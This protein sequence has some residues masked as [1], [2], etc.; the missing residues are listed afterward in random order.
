MSCKTMKRIVAVTLLISVL[1]SFAGCG[2]KV[3]R[4][5][6]DGYQFT[7][8]YTSVNIGNKDKRIEITLNFGD[9]GIMQ[10]ILEEKLE[11]GSITLA[12]EL[13][14]SVYR[15]G[16]AKNGGIGVAAISFYM[17]LDYTYNESDLVV[18]E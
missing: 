16:E 18:V 8:K 9:D 1:F 10:S 13:P 3:T 14:S 17:P 12:G 2:G 6:W 4:H 11:D 15:Y 5:N 7:T